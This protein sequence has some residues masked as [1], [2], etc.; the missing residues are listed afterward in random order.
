MQQAGITKN[1]KTITS[2]EVYDFLKNNAD[3]FLLNSDL[4]EEL[5]LPA[6]SGGNVTSFND[7]QVKKLKNKIEKLEE[8]NKLLISTSLQNHKSEREINE[9]V[10]HILQSKNLEELNKT[11]QSHMLSTLQL[12]SVIIET[13]ETDISSFNEN[14]SVSLR[15]MLDE[16]GRRIHGQSSEVKS[17][18]HIQLLHE[19][20]VIGMLILGSND[21]TRFH[22]GQGTEILEFLGGILGHHLSQLNG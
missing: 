19:G 11:L 16:D 2:E 22:V 18:A 14:E 10:L 3:F 5:S 15:S 8:R 7:F 1:E 17:D 9:L 4:L 21:A 12:D 6:T 13:G 20:N